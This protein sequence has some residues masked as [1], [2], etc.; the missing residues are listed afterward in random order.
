MG[1]ATQKSPNIWLM[2]SQGKQFGAIM[3]DPFAGTKTAAERVAAHVRALAPSIHK[4]ADPGCHLYLWCPTEA[5]QLGIDLMDIWGWHYVSN[6]VWT[7]PERR[8]DGYFQNATE[9]LLFGVRK[10]QKRRR[11]T[12]LRN[13]PNSIGLVPHGQKP[14]DRRDANGKP[15]EA[16]E[17]IEKMST[18][19]YLSLFCT[20]K[21]RGW[22]RAG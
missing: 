5:L 11:R 12:L 6:L 22:T 1:R 17:I 8:W 2:A 10:Y 9:N 20:G 7:R 13:V 18:G 19:P 14:D 4:V 16:Y 21:R 15:I 3:A